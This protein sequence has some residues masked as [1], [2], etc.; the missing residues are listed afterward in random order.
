M[1]CFKLLKS[2]KSFSIIQTNKC[3]GRLTKA[4]AD[5]IQTCLTAEEC[6]RTH[7]VF[8]TKHILNVLIIITLEHIPPNVFENKENCRN[9][10]RLKLLVQILKKF[11]KIRLHYEG[12]SNLEQQ[13][14]D[15]NVTRLFYLKINKTCTWI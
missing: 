8:Q 15:R 3:Q 5:L 9:D 10:H 13:E 6:F 7:N 1:H 12:T 14:Q 11:F 2:E 4:S